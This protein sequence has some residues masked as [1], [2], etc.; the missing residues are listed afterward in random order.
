M[1]GVR[2]NIRIEI[3]AVLKKYQQFEEIKRADNSK[4]SAKISK[5]R[6]RITEELQI[7]SNNWEITKWKKLTHCRAGE[8][9]VSHIT[10]V[11]ENRV[12]FKSS[13]WTKR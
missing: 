8:G 6:I 13:T 3:E 11:W 5:C 9:S 10:K 4:E 2:E 1:S 12:W 7:E